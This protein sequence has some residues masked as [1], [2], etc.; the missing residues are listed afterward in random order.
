MSKE[1][2]KKISILIILFI[3][4]FII[5]YFKFPS[6]DDIWNYGFSYNFATGLTMYNDFNMVIPP[7]YPLIF[8]TILK[9]LGANIIIF[10]LFNALIPTT[11]I[12]LVNKYYKNATLEVTAFLTVFFIANYNILCLLLLT[13]LLIL[14]DKKKSDYT[15]GFFLGLIFLTKTNMIL[16]CLASFFYIK[17]IKKIIRRIIAFII[18]NLIILIYFYKNNI[19][20]NYLNYAYGG[21]LSFGKDNL[22]ITIGVIIIAIIIIVLIREFYKT[23]DIKV[24]Y[25][26]L[27]QIMSYP[28]FN[29]AHISYCLFPVIIYYANK[30]KNP[31]YNRYKKLL[32]VLI[33]TPLILTFIEF[34]VI[35]LEYGTNALKYKLLK[36][37]YTINANMIKQ[38][39]EDLDNTYFIMYEAYF[40]KLLLGIKINKYDLTLKGN[41]GYNGEEETIKYF[42]SLPSG[43]KFLIYNQFEGGQASEKI[44][45]HIKNNY[46]FT[47]AFNNYILY[48]K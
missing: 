38:N 6:N 48:T 2:L 14:E 20:K 30:I 41:L 47:K 22:K 8:G 40:N 29:F 12:Y 25:I 23:K 3:Y 21:L 26:L 33:L 43:T 13:I 27:F 15:I 17:D 42:D 9:L 44:Y 31:I 10:S 46:K 24:L 35:K 19:L 37:K 32:I 45:N 5:S 4:I 36:E 18:P 7:L 16:L 1:K 11:I 34:K 28:I 39:V